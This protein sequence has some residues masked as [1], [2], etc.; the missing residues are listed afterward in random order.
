MLAGQRHKGFTIVELL[1]VI[2]VIAILAAITIVAYNGIQQRAR[3]SI[4]SQD[5]ATIKKAL[6]TYD[7]AYGGVKKVSSYNSS[8][9]SHGGWD[10]STDAN[11]LAFL[12]NEFGNVPLDPTN[13]LAYPANGPDPSNRVYFYYCYNQGSGSLPAT[14]NARIG[15]FK[16]SGAGINEYFPITN[17]L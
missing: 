3:D 11:W 1:I 7:A 6:L 16:E 12:K 15:Y 10:V 5:L 13:N 4:R 2:V 14:P 9:S 8:G 17:C